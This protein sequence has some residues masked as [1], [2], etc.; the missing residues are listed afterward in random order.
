[1]E[2]YLGKIVDV[3]VDR[4]MGSRHPEHGFIYPI[5]YGYIPETM[6]AD[7]EEIDAYIL[8]EFKP[9][10][11]FKGIVIAVIKRKDDIEDKLVVAET[12]NSYDIAQIKSLTE[13]TEK[14]FD[15]EIVCYS[16][17]VG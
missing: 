2:E 1:M 11:K 12:L 14:Y 10:E 7:G 16:G 4:Q 15:T 8:G 13:F 3:I 5:N 6:A 9:I 17:N